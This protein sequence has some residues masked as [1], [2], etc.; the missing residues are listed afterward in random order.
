MSTPSDKTSD[1]FY[2]LAIFVRKMQFIIS[3]Y[4][5]K[6]KTNR[7]VQQK[8]PPSKSNSKACL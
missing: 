2:C 7:I 5:N 4:G 6:G 8:F 3:L 1:F